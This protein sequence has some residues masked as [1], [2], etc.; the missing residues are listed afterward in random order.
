MKFSI[1][2]ESRLGGRKSNQDRTGYVYSRNALLMLVADG[3]GGHL[4]GEIAAQIAVEFIASQFRD[5]ATPRLTNP[6]KFLS[7]SITA[8]HHAIFE[9]AEKRTLLETP[10]TTLV[11]ALVQDGDVWWA[12]V[13]DSRF[14]WLRGE[15]VVAQTI[16]HSRVAQLVKAGTIREE[17]VARHPDRNR[18]FNCL[19][20]HVLPTVEVSKKNRLQHGDQLVLCTDGLWGPLNSKVIAQAFVGESILTAVPRLMQVAQQRAGADADNIS[21]VAMKWD[22]TDA[23]SQ[24]EQAG[25]IDTHVTTSFGDRQHSTR[26]DPMNVTGRMSALSEDEI[27]KA[28]REIRTAIAKTTRNEH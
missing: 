8:A 24:A 10:R 11:A 25:L 14:Y 22:E 23:D 4:H 27:E 6:A 15:Q 21:A 16:D 26:I 20:A 18:V 2:Q 9:Y 28:I 12:H 1:F 7:D 17:D 3:M 19:G 5:K 13:G